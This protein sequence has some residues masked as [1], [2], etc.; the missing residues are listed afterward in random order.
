MS[1]SQFS[2]LRD[3]S[4]GEAPMA[5]RNV[6]HNRQR[7]HDHGYPNRGT[8]SGVASAASVQER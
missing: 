2:E 7:A 8:R 6:F 1:A 5:I 3:V 4:A